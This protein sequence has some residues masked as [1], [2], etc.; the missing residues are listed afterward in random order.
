MAALGPGPV[1]ELDV[2]R[3]FVSSGYDPVIVEL[4]PGEL[5]RAREA[6]WH[7]ATPPEYDGQWWNWCRMPSAA[8][9]QADPTTVAVIPAVASHLSRWLGRE[10][11]SE[12]AGVTAPKRPSPHS[13]PKH[14]RRSAGGSA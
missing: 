3:M 1:S 10:I 8:G 13:E 9:G 11:E 4:R 6:H 7:R 14:G 12:S 5:Q 2:L